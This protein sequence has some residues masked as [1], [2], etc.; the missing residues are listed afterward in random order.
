MTSSVENALDDVK[1]RHDEMNR[2]LSSLFPQFRDA[3]ERLVNELIR[4][5]QEFERQEEL[6]RVRADNDRAHIEKLEEENQLLRQDKQE[7]DKLR[8]ACNRQNQKLDDYSNQIDALTD[9]NTQLT[10]Q[11]RAADRELSALRLKNNEFSSELTRR[12]REFD[13][14]RDQLELEKRTDLSNQATEHLEAM[15]KAKR[16]FEN[17]LRKLEV[18]FDKRDRDV[19]DRDKEIARL[20]QELRALPLKLQ[21]NLVQSL[22]KQCATQPQPVTLPASPSRR[23]SASNPVRPMRHA[24]AGSSISSS[25]SSA[26]SYSS[27]HHGSTEPTNKRSRR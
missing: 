2:A 20:N 22:R 4:K 15:A 7:H 14:M 8:A 5:V 1:R 13:E 17:S 10:D 9:Q 11:F 24:I 25:A 6:Y 12:A 23:K 16:A 3:S 21:A 18:D 26:S 19:R 27:R